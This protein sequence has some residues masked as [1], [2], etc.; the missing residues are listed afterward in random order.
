[1]PQT[2][3]IK[4]HILIVNSNITGVATEMVSIS[5]WNTIKVISDNFGEKS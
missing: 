2:E 5:L 3:R 4:L 1:M